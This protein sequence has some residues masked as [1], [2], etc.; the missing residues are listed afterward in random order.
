MELNHWRVAVELC[1]TLSDENVSHKL[2]YLNPW[3]SV[4][5]AVWRC[6][7]VGN[8]SLEAGFVHVIGSWCW[9]FCACGSRCELSASRSK[10]HACL[11]PCLP[12]MRTVDLYVSGTISFNKLF[13][14]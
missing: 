1:G 9:Q 5:A 4:G 3:S 8:M 2:V 14:L 11:L 6:G 7:F 13:F 12:G 10:L